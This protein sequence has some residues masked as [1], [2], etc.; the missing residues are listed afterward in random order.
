V[1]ATIQHIEIYLPE[2]VLTNEELALQLPGWDPVE[3]YEKVGIKQRHIT[4]PGETALDLAQK[5]CEKL[6][7]NWGRP[8]VDFMML[9][10]Q[11]PDHFLPSSSCLLQ[12][13]LNMPDSVGAFDFALGC[14]G[15]VYGLA[16]AKG[17]IAG[18][19]ASTILLVTAETLSKHIHPK[20]KANRS[21]AGDAA[22]AT[23]ITRTDEENIQDFVLGTDGN[24]KDMIVPYG[25]CRH[26]YDVNAEEYT[27]ING[28]VRSNNHYY[29]NGHEVFNFTMK[30]VP[31]LV[32]EVMARN[33][34]TID[35]VDYF[36]FHQANKF[37][38]DHLRKMSK[39]PSEKFYLN[40]ENTGN[41]SSCTIPIALK[42]A[43][44][45][46]LIKKGDKVL[47]A[48]FGIGYSWA[49]TIITI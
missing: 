37:I 4:A 10:T 22:A 30:K 21:L 6:F 5:V 13:R 42:D 36:I 2:K 31:S 15:F 44:E 25:A 48:G 3:I 9:C 29:M 11:S 33:N 16:T 43:L 8:P 7:E 24:E 41:T 46:K 1:G 19:L 27:D 14:S 18:G 45:R 26:P 38:I 40:M 49:G 20:D 34:L 47:L 32:S 35:T 39:I 17:L 12:K 23:I 28:N